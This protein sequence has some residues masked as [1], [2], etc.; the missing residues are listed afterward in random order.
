MKFHRLNLLPPEDLQRLGHEKLA[1]FLVLILGLHTAALFAGGILMLPTYFFLTFQEKDTLIQIDLA[2]KSIQAERVK[3]TED[4]IKAINAKLQSLDAA[5]SQR[6]LL[7]SHIAAVGRHVNPG[8]SLDRL[9]FAR[10]NR[11]IEITG[12]APT[13]EEFLVF[14]DRLRNDPY[15]ASVESPVNN[16]LK[17]TNV[18]FILTLLLPKK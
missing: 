4:A 15:F 2:Q 10:E 11:K 7:S 18:A 12:K 16:L 9:T 3:E 1:R 13:R 17:D 14:L 5:N 8:I 6:S